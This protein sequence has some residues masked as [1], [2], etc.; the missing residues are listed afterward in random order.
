M[1]FGI[2]QDFYNHEAS[3]G[4]S[5]NATGVV[6]TTL[7]GVMY[8]SMPILSTVLDSGRWAK[9]RRGVATCGVCLSSAAFLISSWSTQVWHLIVLQGVLAAL[10]GAM[11]FSPVT[12]FLDEWFKH[13]NRASAYGVQ[14]SSK[15]IVGT[16]CPFLMYALLNRL[17]FR[18]ALRVWSGI[19]FATGLFGL[20][21]IPRSS[22]TIS[23]RPRK[24]PWTFLRHKTFYIY[25]VGNVVFS[26]GY[27]LPQ[28]YLS[29]YASNVLHL[30]DILSTMMIAIFNGRPPAQCAFR[31]V[32]ASCE[33][34][35]SV[36]Y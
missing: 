27:G 21:I 32:V 2:F 24:V 25:A 30:S 5:G 6:G 28:T 33:D 7:N 34:G 23:R 26:S 15:N 17:G 22:T 16:G 3:F 10:G 35:L 14:L 8:L 12:L 13:G 4:D 9:W 18:G 1:T 20:Y 36:E 11:M 29:Q 31:K 19:V